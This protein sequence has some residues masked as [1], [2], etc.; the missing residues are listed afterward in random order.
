MAKA[1]Q[2]KARGQ[3]GERGLVA[4]R[5]P[6]AA[7][8]GIPQRQ[9]DRAAAGGSALGRDKEKSCRSWPVGSPNV[10]NDEALANM[11]ERSPERHAPLLGESD[12]SHTRVGRH[13]LYWSPIWRRGA[14]GICL[15]NLA[16]AR[17][18]FDRKVIHAQSQAN[19]IRAR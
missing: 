9:A 6:V 12:L 17:H 16:K 13:L 11:R 8:G 14:R 5:E 15:R 1:D 7:L 3:Q 18:Y 19:D 4:G 2:P 10:V